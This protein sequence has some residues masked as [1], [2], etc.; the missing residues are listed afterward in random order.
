MLRLLVLLLLLANGLYYAWSHDL[1]RAY[2]FAPLQQSEPQRMAQ[3][4]RPE[5]VRVLPAD[6]A[7]AT[8]AAVKGGECLQAGVFDDN[9]ATVLRQ[10]AQTALPAG[11]WVLEPAVEPARWIIYMGKY[12][13]A[14]ALARKRAELVALNLNLRF[15]ALSNPA[16]EFGLS[17]GAFESEARAQADLA[18]LSQRGVHTARVVQERGEQRGSMF[19]IPVLDDAVR[20]HLE[21]LKPALA[22]RALRACR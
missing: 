6:E 8:E 4:I 9:Q 2:G 7:Q 14:Q 20:A 1:L 3:Q 21:E 17:L 5:A 10:A 15:E 22:G 18:A 13:D 16:L 12:P 11:S 19:R